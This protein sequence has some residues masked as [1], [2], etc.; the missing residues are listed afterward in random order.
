VPARLEGHWELV[1][2]GYTSANAYDTFSFVQRGDYYFTR[3]GAYSFSSFAHASAT[4]TRS[5]GA[6]IKAGGTDVLGNPTEAPEVHTSAE[7]SDHGTY[8]IVADRIHFTG[9][10]GSRAAATVYAAGCDQD[11][12][13]RT[14]VLFLGG[15]IYLRAKS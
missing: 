13:D 8:E 4:N 5:G 12:D 14:G 1:D 7:G 15:S 11:A 6:P 3:D 9:A 2:G 10:D